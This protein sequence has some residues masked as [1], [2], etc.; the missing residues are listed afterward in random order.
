MQTSGCGAYFSCIIFIPSNSYWSVSLLYLHLPQNLRFCARNNVSHV[1]LC[2]AAVSDRYPPFALCANF[3]TS[4]G[5]DG[6][7]VCGYY[8]TLS[9]TNQGVSLVWN[10]QFIAVWNQSKGLN[11]ITAT[12]CMASSRRDFILYALRAI[13]CA[14]SSQFHT[15]RG[16]RWFHTKPAAWIKKEVTFGKQKLLLFLAEKERFELSRR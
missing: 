15:T 12:P 3:H 10:P 5:L 14:T 8:I 1:A 9:Q 7:T 11:E 6:F 13:P 2:D 16:A 4:C